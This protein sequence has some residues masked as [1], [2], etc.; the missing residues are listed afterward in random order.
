MHQIFVLLKLLRKVSEMRKM[1]IKGRIL[2]FAEALEH[3]LRRKECKYLAFA[4]KFYQSLLSPF[5]S[6]LFF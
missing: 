1:K 4:C 3:S 2:G 5:F 6:P